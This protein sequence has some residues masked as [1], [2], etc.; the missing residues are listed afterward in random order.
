MTRFELSICSQDE[1]N[2]THENWIVRPLSL[3]DL[4]EPKKLKSIQTHSHTQF[5]DYNSHLETIHCLPHYSSAVASL[6]VGIVALVVIFACGVRFACYSRLIF[7]SVAPSSLYQILTI[8]SLIFFPLCKYILLLPWVYSHAVLWGYGWYWSFV[9]MGDFVGRSVMEL[10]E[11][12][13]VLYKWGIL[14]IHFV[15]L[16]CFGSFATVGISMW[17]CVTH[18]TLAIFMLYSTFIF[19][20]YSLILV[21]LMAMIP[22]TSFDF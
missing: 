19:F 2:F 11:C 15:V 13:S 9:E 8:S 4:Y 21:N 12:C 16:K 17:C 10:I 6:V 18:G 14:T 1:I 7:A 20:A 5:L 22:S 3:P